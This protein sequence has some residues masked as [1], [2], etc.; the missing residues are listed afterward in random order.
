MAEANGQGQGGIVLT[1]KLVEVQAPEPYVDKKTG[2]KKDG[3]LRAFL[4]VGREVQ[5]VGC[6]KDKERVFAEL[7]RDKGPLALV[8]VPVRP[9][10]QGR[11]WG[12][13]WTANV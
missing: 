9:P 3:G 10:Y 8:S 12:G 1:G 11:E 2:E 7:L 4:L 6:P 13:Y 5:T